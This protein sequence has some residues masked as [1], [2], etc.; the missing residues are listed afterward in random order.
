MFKPAD[1]VPLPPQRMGIR[2]M[3]KSF[4]SARREAFSA[5]FRCVIV[6]AAVAEGIGC[7]DGAAVGVF[8]AYALAP[9]VVAVLRSK[10][11]A[12]RRVLILRRARDLARARIYRSHGL[13]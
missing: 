9:C 12:Q 8:D 3:Q 4:P 11:A 5:L 1:T 6:I 10:L 7:A 2:L 13:P